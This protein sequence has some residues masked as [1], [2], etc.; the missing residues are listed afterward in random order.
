MSFFFP[1][2]LSGFAILTPMLV[3]AR[4]KTE[5]LKPTCCWDRGFEFLWGHG[6]SSVVFVV[7]CVDSGLWDGL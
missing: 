4:S 7:C 6:R 5:S 2:L 3:A 1:I